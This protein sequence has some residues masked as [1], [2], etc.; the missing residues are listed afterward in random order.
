MH[1][2]DSLGSYVSS[3]YISFGKGVDEIVVPIALFREPEIAVY[4]LIGAKLFFFIFFF[5]LFCFV[6]RVGKFTIKI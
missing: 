3:R 6:V 1:L 5:V 2:H 4:Q